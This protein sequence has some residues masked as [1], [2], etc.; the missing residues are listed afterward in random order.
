MTISSTTELLASYR[1]EPGV[2][3]EMLTAGGEVREHWEHAGRVIEGLGLEE[4]LERRSKARRLLDDDGVTYNIYG[5][6][7]ASFSSPS[8]AAPW[9]LDPVPVLLASEEWAGIELGV[10]QRA[11]LLNLVLT[12]LYGPRELLR[13]GLLPAELILGHP[14]F[15]RQCDQIRVPGNQQLFSTAVDLARD[16]A[17]NCTVLADHTQAPSG[18]GY[19][20][21]NRVVVSRVFPSLYRDSQ[22]HRLA[23]FF[24][25]MRASFE[26]VAPPDADEPRIVLLSPGPWS[27]TAF[28]HAYLASYLGY[29]LV[30]GTDLTVRDGRVWLRSLGRLERV[31][32]IVRRTDAGFCD[33]LE[34]R[35]DSKL[36]V[37]GLV[38]AARVGGVSIVNTLGSGVLENPGLAPYLPRLA[39]HLLG[40]QLLL[41]SVPTWWCGDDDGRRH[42]L[43]HLDELVIKPISRGLGP[44]SVFPWELSRERRDDLRRRIEANPASWVGQETVEL[45]SAPTLTP[46]GLEARRTILRAFAIARNDSYT[47]MPG[48]LTRVAAANGPATG[49]H[50]NGANARGVRISNQAGA[51]SKDT[52]VLA[53][54]PEKLSGFW[55]AAGPP[56]AAVD[57]E[58]S[59][60]SRAAENLFWLG[61]YA[62]RAETM[63]RLLRAAHD[64]RDF[65]VQGSN[66]AG[67]ECL[68]VLL[69]AI[70]RISSTYP[71]FVGDG[72]A[73]RLAAPGAELFS[74]VVDEDRAGTLAHAVHHLIRAA[75]SVRDQLSPDTWL[76]IGT[77]D[78]EIRDLRMS[79]PDRPRIAQH[80]LGRI[81]QSL[82]AL[83]GLAAESMVRDPGWRFMDAGRRIERALQLAALLRT[84]V[85]VERS[86]ATDSLL[87]ESVL[88]AAESV[89]TYRRRYRSHAQI[90]TLLDLLVFDADNPRSLAYQLDRIAA[91]A[92]LM[93]RLDRGPR[94]SEPQRLVLETSTALGLA[95]S[96]VLAGPDARHERVELDAF[97]TNILE[98]LARTAD[99]VDAD[100]FDHPLPQRSLVSS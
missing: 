16:A 17:G 64:R 69:G 37:P 22:V 49:G 41:P 91:D 65:Q 82:L 83:S 71:G 1:P 2:Y 90:E 93:P 34:L 35:P 11:E 46:S 47:A 19:A 24:R 20:L 53:S 95:D 52:W 39:E 6:D 10:V 21:E 63:A 77:L 54:E 48:G 60:S 75:R 38:E 80:T 68:E 51:I 7:D 59:M 61:R 50:A 94:L 30:E 14:G 4:L 36:G 97:L 9:A 70:T 3:D 32:V 44:T 73:G 99:A 23:P 67:T 43:A 26:A 100:H 31:D 81:M 57:P 78:R 28:E 25:M 56:V 33:P 88:I 87:I 5:S 13:R 8:P 15:L 45:A 40:E 55:L 85:T 98:L 92:R 89:I 76:V 74:L 84:T 86:T 66:P 72:S 12:D 27:E 58:A 79:D 96:A 18:A 62:E 29:P 42:V